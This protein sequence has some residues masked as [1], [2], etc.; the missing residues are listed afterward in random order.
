MD[1]P[2][3]SHRPR[4][5]TVRHP[6]CS[7][8]V[9]P[10]HSLMVGRWANVVHNQLPEKQHLCT[11]LAPKDPAALF[12]TSSCGR[13]SQVWGAGSQPS[14]YTQVLYRTQS[15]QQQPDFLI[16]SIQPYSQSHTCLYICCDPAVWFH[17]NIRKWIMLLPKW[18]SDSTLQHTLILQP[19]EWCIGICSSSK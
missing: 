5:N 9:K 15:K 2:F 17:R 12:P 3:S 16:R 14:H 7:T 8:H 4:E 18:S 13:G 1:L 6:P 19:T 11:H 10:L